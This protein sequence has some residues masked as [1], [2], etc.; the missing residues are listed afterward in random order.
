MAGNAARSRQLSD[1]GVQKV[2]S[3]LE[4]FGT[5]SDLACRV[6][7]CRV[8]QSPDFCKG[9]PVAIQDRSE[10]CKKLK[11]TLEDV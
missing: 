5:I 6:D 10:I 9:E 3:A 7:R 2:N 1:Q 8:P 4:K 11:L